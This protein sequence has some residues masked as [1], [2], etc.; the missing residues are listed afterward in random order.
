[1]GAEMKPRLVLIDGVPVAKDTRSQAVQDA[2]KRYGRKFASEPWQLGE[3][4][5]YFTSERVAA[6]AAEN[7]TLRRKRK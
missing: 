7:E 5:R 2:E 3:G 1:M 4:P 6:L